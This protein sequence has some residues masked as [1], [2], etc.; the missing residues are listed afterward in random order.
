[1]HGLAVSRCPLTLR[2]KK[3]YTSDS[4]C[5][6]T[7]KNHH[8]SFPYQF[9]SQGSSRAKSK[10]K[11]GRIATRRFPPSLKKEPPN[12]GLVKKILLLVYKKC[13]HLYLFYLYFSV[14][15]I[16]RYLINWK[17]ALKLIFAA[18]Y[19]LRSKHRRI[20]LLKISWRLESRLNIK[21]EFSSTT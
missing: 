18:K 21:R 13:C 2:R 12:G 1:M 20:L 8:A 3:L 7:D 4:R 10:T 9:L 6:V 11:Q 14:F 16:L 5:N 19:C 17:I 15:K